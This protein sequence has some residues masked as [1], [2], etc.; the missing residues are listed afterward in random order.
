M[1]TFYVLP[2]RPF[3]AERLAEYLADWFPGL[4]LPAGAELLD[5][6]DAVVRR[7]DV[8]ILHREDLPD[9]EDVSAALIDGFGAEAGDEVI[10]VRAGGPG[11]APQARRWR[12]APRAAA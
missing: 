5:L 4:P 9:G 7:A 12:I 10:E 2:P 8:F 1:S 11:G 3:V 6:V